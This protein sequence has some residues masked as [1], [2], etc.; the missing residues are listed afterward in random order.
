MIK[1]YSTRKVG[2]KKEKQGQDLKGSYRT[3]NR[4]KIEGLVERK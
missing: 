2:H 1:G 3:E 4:S